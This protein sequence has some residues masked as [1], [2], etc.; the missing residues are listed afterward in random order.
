MTYLIRLKQL[1]SKVPKLYP[2]L[3]SALHIHTLSKQVQEKNQDRRWFG[4]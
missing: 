2:Q 3:I 4:S 1:K